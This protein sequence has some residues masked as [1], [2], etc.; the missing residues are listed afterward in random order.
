MVV[1][2]NLKDED[3]DDNDIPETYQQK[4]KNH[5]AL[6]DIRNS[7]SLSLPMNRNGSGTGWNPDRSPMYKYHLYTH[8]WLFMAHGDVFMRFNK[9]DIA[10]AGKRGSEQWD[11]TDWLAISGHRKSGLDGLF[12]FNAAFSTDILFASGNGLGQLFQTAD[13]WNGYAMGDRKLPNNVLSELSVSYAYSFADNGDLFI[14]GGYPAEPALGPVSCLKRPSTAF[15]PDAPLGHSLTDATNISMGVATMGLR[16]HRFKLEG[17]SFTGRLPDRNNYDF[18]LPFFN[19][20]SGRLSYN[21]SAHWAIQVSRGFICSPDITHPSINVNRTTASATYVAAMGPRKYWAYTLLWGQNEI[22][23]HIPSSTALLEGTY[24][25]KKLVAYGRYE[26]VQK[27]GEE[28]YL[29]TGMFNSSAQFNIH[30]IT[31]GGSYDLLGLK[32]CMIAA[33]A[34]LTA[35]LTD[36]SLNRVYGQYPIAGQIYLHILPMLQ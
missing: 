30:A 6:E 36:A 26:W 4:E 35:H 15:I 18:N 23:G 32:Y 12:H 28:L 24:R 3:D 16:I 1:P 7:Y 2:I 5:A 29:S 10:S 19:S 34:Q 27:T 22:A 13:R 21:P 14:Y 8:K 20:Y 31:A 11:V 9:Q 33:G 17:S 25:R